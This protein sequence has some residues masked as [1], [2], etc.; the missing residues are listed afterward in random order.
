MKLLSI[1][2]YF[3]I[4]LD[5]YL[6]KNW[7]LWTHLRTSYVKYFV[8]HLTVEFHIKRPSLQ[9]GYVFLLWLFPPTDVMK[10]TSSWLHFFT[11]KLTDFIMKEVQIIFST[12]HAI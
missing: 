2:K 4:F 11:G 7:Q 5:V 9:M 8:C 6:I 10:S 12:A 3:L 1:L